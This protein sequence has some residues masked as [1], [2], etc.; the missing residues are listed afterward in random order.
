MLF[1]INNVCVA[2]PPF[3]FISPG[4]AQEVV[5]SG[6]VALIAKSFSNTGPIREHMN[7]DR[8]G[9]HV[10]AVELSTKHF[11]VGITKPLK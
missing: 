1:L 5:W 3:H 4:V 2:A 6:N 11:S 8:P 10:D 9:V 7:Y